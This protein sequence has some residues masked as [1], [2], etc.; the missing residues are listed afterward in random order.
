MMK[1]A[2]AF[3]RSYVLCAMAIFLPLSAFAD[4]TVVVTAKP[5]ENA[6]APTQGY[7]VKTSK[8]ATKSGRA[9]L[10][11]GLSPNPSAVMGQ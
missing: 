8:A 5:A 3:K 11:A 10:R 9:S 4:D 6:D 2:Y 1:L 7:T